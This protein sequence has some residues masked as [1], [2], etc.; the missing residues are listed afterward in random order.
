MVVGMYAVMCRGPFG[1]DSF[2]VGLGLRT[3]GRALVNDLTTPRTPLAHSHHNA[4]DRKTKN[5]SP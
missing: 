4:N 3:L 1:A 2:A 5:D